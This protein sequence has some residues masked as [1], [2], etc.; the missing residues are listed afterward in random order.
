[1]GLIARVDFPSGFCSLWLKVEGL[2]VGTSQED[3]PL[4]FQPLEDQQA[5][6]LGAEDLGR[7]GGWSL[8]PRPASR[9]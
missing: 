3:L 4:N 2:A 5:E 9:L 6:S 1:M 7:L 8:S